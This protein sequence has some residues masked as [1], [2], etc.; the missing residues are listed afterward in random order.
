MGEEW[1]KGHVCERNGK[2]PRIVFSKRVPSAGS[3]VYAGER[4][5]D[6][7]ET[8]KEKK[9]NFGK[10]GNNIL[11]SCERQKKKVNI[12]LGKRESAPTRKRLSIEIIAPERRGSAGP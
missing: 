10:G 2:G 4:G 8:E 12:N 7:I 3:P 5:K 9:R 11:I 6:P 1:E